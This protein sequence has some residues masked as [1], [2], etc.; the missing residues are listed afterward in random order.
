[1]KRYEHKIS[2]IPM[3]YQVITEGMLFFKKQGLPIDPDMAAFM[4][5]EAVQGHM[6]L[7]QKDGYELVAVQS[8]L[9]G[10]TQTSTGHG[11]SP[12]GFAYPITAGFVLFWKREGC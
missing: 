7:Y 6:L 8:V 9:K 10:V 4:S 3:P 2:F 12:Y 1:M 11:P 5:D